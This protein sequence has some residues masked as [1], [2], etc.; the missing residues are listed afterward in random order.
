MSREPQESWLEYAIGNLMIL[1]PGAFFAWMTVLARESRLYEL[2]FFLGLIAGGLLV[3][4][5]V[6][7][8]NR[9]SNR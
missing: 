7:I 1:A 6:T 2:G 9:W 5:F 3:W 4:A 8:W